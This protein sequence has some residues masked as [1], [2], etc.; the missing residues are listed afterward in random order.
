MFEP[1]ALGLRTFTM[2]QFRTMLR[3]ALESENLLSTKYKDHI[4]NTN[5]QSFRQ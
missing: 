4:T 5:V 3:K 1:D 2:G